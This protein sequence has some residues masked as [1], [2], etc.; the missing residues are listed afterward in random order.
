MTTKRPFLAALTL[1]TWL[2]GAAA[3]QQPPPPGYAPPPADQPPP[4]YAQPP[5]G[6]PQQ[7]QVYA[8]PPGYAP[9]PGYTPPPPAYAPPPPQGSDAGAGPARFGSGMQLVISDDLFLQL[10]TQ[11]TT[12]PGVLGGE[13]TS[14]SSTSVYLRP[15]VDL[16]VARNFSIGGQLTMGAT[17]YDAG[18]VTSGGSSATFGVM[19]RLGFNIPLGSK[20][21]IWLRGAAGYLFTSYSFDG[22]SDSTSGYVFEVQG[23]APLLVHPVPHFFIGIGPSLFAQ[24]VSKV[25]DEDTTRFSSF[26]LQSTIGGYL[27]GR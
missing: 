3:A 2:A 22:S 19:P 6:D 14:S 11:T 27:G 26:G 12:T 9:P 15:A 23:F 25:E 16:F 24:I 4:G 20:V 1:T 21:S 18:S 7:P 17:S 8:Q 13:D 10:V 5:Q